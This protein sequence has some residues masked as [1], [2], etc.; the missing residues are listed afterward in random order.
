MKKL[1]LASG[2]SYRKA[3]LERL[4]LPFEVC[5]P[6]IDETALPGESAA[7]L[8]QRLARCKA[9]AISE[10]HGDAVV[11]G[12]DQVAVV[13]ST[14]LGK[15]GTAVLARQQLQACS[16]REVCFL[17]GVH[18]IRP[19]GDD[20]VGIEAF[21]VF[22]RQLAE[23]EIA[24]YIDIERPLDCAGSIKWEGLGITLFQR[25]SG[26]DPTTLEGLPLIRLA[27]MLRQC[28]LDPLSS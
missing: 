20:L 16:G 14:I 9:Q 13:D 28:G 22:F 5:A 27:E 3:L 4:Q 12:S 23:T 24:R 15:P 21:K 17:T 19:D 26:D 2:S 11:I 8:C 6:E 1:I 25:L 7:A 18:V 10:L